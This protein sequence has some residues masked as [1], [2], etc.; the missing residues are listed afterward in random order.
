MCLWEEKNIC[1]YKAIQKI[2]WASA[3]VSFEGWE[4]VTEIVQFIL[5]LNK[6]VEGQGALIR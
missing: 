4:H 3:S 5:T 1:I 2:V 6:T